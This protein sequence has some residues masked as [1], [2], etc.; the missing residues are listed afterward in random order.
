MTVS[1]RLL[2]DVLYVRQE[3]GSRT[4]HVRGDIITGIPGEEVQRLLKTGALA[5]RSGST[6]PAAPADPEPPATG[7]ADPGQPS[8]ATARPPRIASKPVL[9][10]WLI[11]HAGFDRGELEAQTKPDLWALIDATD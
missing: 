5:E 6:A 1:Y 9:V 8:A 7:P 2:A 3:D 10:D 4:R 11:E